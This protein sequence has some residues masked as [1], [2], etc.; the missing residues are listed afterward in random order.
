MM[1]RF[2]LLCC[3]LWLS[4]CAPELPPAPTA[5]LTPPPTPAP[6]YVEAGRYYLPEGLDGY[7]V[8]VNGTQLGVLNEAKTLI[9]SISGVTSLPSDETPEETLTRYLG[10]VIA[11]GNGT[12]EKGA[13]TPITV[14]GVSGVSAEISGTLYGFAFQGEAFLLPD[15]PQHFLFGFGISNVS[16]EPTNWET[17]GQAVFHTLRDTIRF[18]TPSA[19]GCILSVDETYGDL[20]NPIK[21][22]GGPLDGPTREDVYLSTLRGPNGEPLTYTDLGA[23]ESGDFDAFE[24]S[25]LPEPVVLV[26]DKYNY[27]PLRA[28]VGFTCASAFPLTSP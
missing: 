5:T 12:Y 17:E 20:S 26:M 11:E 24:I 1:K 2:L 4:A 16:K 15:T 21:V 13:T 7:N 22:G 18:L 10:A 19:A 27:E 23:S 25:G 6:I 28:P 8:Q 3:V 9:I 14:S